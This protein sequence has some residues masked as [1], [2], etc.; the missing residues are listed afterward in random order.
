M[1]CG[2]AGGAQRA[3][4]FECPGVMSS[5]ALLLYKMGCENWWWDGWDGD[6][7]GQDLMGV[8]GTTRRARFCHCEP[9]CEPGT[10]TVEEKSTSIGDSG[11]R[12]PCW[13]T[14]LLSCTAPS[15]SS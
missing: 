12:L 3:S 11:L 15:P 10:V 2:G 1:K 13:V 8:F 14:S 6:W 9:G 7:D 4:N 5:T